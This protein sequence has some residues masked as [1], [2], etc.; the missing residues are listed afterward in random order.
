MQ[1]R[2]QHSSD[3]IFKI[4]RVYF[5]IVFNLLK[6]DDTILF[7]LYTYITLK[8]KFTTDIKVHKTVHI[9]H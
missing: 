3:L 4:P 6:I 7:I 5:L 2:V 9:I 8:D 1:S